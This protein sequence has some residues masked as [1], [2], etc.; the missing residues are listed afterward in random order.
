MR[1]AVL[2]GKKTPEI[3]QLALSIVECV[4]G[5]NWRREISALFEWTR[6]RIRYVLDPVD[7][8]MLHTGAAVLR[9]GQSDCDGQSVLLASLLE[10]IGHRTRFVAIS[11]LPGEYRHVYAQTVCGKDARGNPRWLSLD[12]TEPYPMGWEPPGICDRMIIHNRR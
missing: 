10:S 2:H 6:A 5:K 1:L 4:P 3:R 9:D 8:E 11:L 7:V 12:T